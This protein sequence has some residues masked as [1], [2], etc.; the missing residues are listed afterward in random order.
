MGFVVHLGQVLKIQMGVDLGGGD[1]G[2]T[3]QLL[4]Q[5]QVTA[6]F[7]HMAGKG[8]AQHMRMDMGIHTLLLTQLLQ[9][10]LNGA[11]TD[12]GATVANK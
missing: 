9:A 4:H 12:T 11:V 3:E 10:Q 2:V 5:T 7:E 8:V 1:I 6:G